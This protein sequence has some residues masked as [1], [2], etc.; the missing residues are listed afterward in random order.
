MS[1]HIDPKLGEAI[2]DAVIK[3]VG[4]DPQYILMHSVRVQWDPD[5]ATVTWDGRATMTAAEMTEILATLD[6]TGWEMQP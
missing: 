2:V 5:T 6:V 1:Y 4:V 3:A